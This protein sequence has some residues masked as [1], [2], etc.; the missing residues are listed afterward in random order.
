LTSTSRRYRCRSSGLKPTRTTNVSRRIPPEYPEVP[1][2]CALGAAACL[3][4]HRRH[5]AG[6]LWAHCALQAAAVHM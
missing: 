5:G 6:T 2:H 1:A 3:G 4:R